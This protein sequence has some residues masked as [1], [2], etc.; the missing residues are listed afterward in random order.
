LGGLYGDLGGEPGVGILECQA[1][2]SAPPH[3]L[4]KYFTSGGSGASLA[5]RLEKPEL[6]QTSEI[7]RGGSFLDL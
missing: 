1:L 4:T 2:G 6:D 3:L 7:P 5:M